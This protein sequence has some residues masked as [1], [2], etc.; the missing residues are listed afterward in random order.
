M[1][2]ACSDIHW[3]LCAPLVLFHLF[4]SKCFSSLNS[5]CHFITARTAVLIRC[6]E[7]VRQNRYWR[8]PSV[9]SGS[10]EVKQKVLFICAGK[11]CTCILVTLFL[12]LFLAAISCWGS[13]RGC[14]GQVTCSFQGPVWAF[15]GSVR[16]SKVPLKISWNFPLWPEHL[17]RFR[18]HWGLNWE[19]SI[20]SPVPHRQFLRNSSGLMLMSRNLLQ[21]SPKYWDKCVVSG[22][23]CLLTHGGLILTLSIRALCL[24]LSKSVHKQHLINILVT[25][26]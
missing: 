4:L 17:P 18:Q 23:S 20:P 21:L 1:L 13:C 5:Y 3:L 14:C 25:T 15:G 22:K 24:T 8:S 11:F 2:L 12:F 16:C 26:G 19:P 10:I 7:L 6:L 9:W